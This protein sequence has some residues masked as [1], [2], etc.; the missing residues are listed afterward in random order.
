MT[1]LLPHNHGVLCVTHNVDDD[2]AVLR[3]D[4]P[5]WAQRLVQ[6][7][8]KTGYF[9]KWHV[10]RSHKLEKYGWQSSVDD[11]SSIYRNMAAVYG[12]HSV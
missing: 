4:K 3:E 11:H 7:G 9:G 2:Q 10:E 8:Y 1:G 5:H 12:L 6:S